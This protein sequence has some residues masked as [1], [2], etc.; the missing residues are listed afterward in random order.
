MAGNDVLVRSG[1]FME[2]SFFLVRHGGN[3]YQ[4][5]KMDIMDTDLDVQELTCSCVAGIILPIRPVI[6]L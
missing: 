3:M 5:G 1:R 4:D 6:L 2:S